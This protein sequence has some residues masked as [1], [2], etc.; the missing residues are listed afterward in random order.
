MSDLERIYK[1]I[2]KGIQNKEYSISMFMNG[3]TITSISICP[4]PDPC[5]EL[6]NLAEDV[7]TRKEEPCFPDIEHLVDVTTP[8]DFERTA[9]NHIYVPG[10]GFSFKDLTDTEWDLYKKG[11]EFDAHTFDK[12]D[13]SILKSYDIDYG[14]GTA[15][16]ITPYN[17]EDRFYTLANTCFGIR[18]SIIK[19]EIINRADVPIPSY[20][21]LAFNGDVYVWRKDGARMMLSPTIDPHWDTDYCQVCVYSEDSQK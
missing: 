20:E 1:I 8:S 16:L 19:C 21:R 6:E 12:Y 5:S 14:F 7:V 13:P 3:D 18:K 11:C 4:W 15:N 9:G 10:P 2:E 17:P